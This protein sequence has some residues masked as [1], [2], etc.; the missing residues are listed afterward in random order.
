MK[1]K[2]D[3]HNEWVKRQKQETDVR[4]LPSWINDGRGMGPTETINN[5]NERAH[6]ERN[7]LGWSLSQRW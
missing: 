5:S 1:T 2:I 7:G 6:R 3:A 4:S